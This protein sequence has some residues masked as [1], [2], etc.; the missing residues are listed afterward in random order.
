M[1]KEVTSR[2]IPPPFVE[3]ALVDVAD[4]AGHHL[5][6]G[7]L[8]DRILG[9]GVFRNEDRR[10]VLDVGRAVAAIGP[11]EI[12]RIVAVRPRRTRSEEEDL[13]AFRLPVA[14]GAA[15]N[16]AL[17]IG[18]DH[19]A[20]MGERVRHDI[21]GALPRTRRSDHQMMALVVDT[22]DLT[23]E[24]PENMPLALEPFAAAQRHHGLEACIAERTGMPAKSCIGDDRRDGDRRHDRAKRDRLKH[25][26]V[27]IGHEL[28]E[29]RERIGRDRRLQHAAVADR[30]TAAP[31][32][33]PASTPHS[34]SRG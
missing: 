30:G 2:E 34:R 27:G 33:K 10:D 23:A 3:D 4:H 26:T 24:A 31:F 29:R 19:R 13:I 11:D 22:Q 14:G 12:E 5:L 16:L 7:R 21:A 20:F 6:G 28:L 9:L 17:Q 8:P 1:K 25:R 18:D 32:R 15:K